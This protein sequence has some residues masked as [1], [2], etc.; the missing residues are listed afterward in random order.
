MIWALFEFEILGTF[1][2]NKK[3]DIVVTNREV[4]WYLEYKD[5]HVGTYNCF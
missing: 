3:S 4:L 1:V 2:L 5:F